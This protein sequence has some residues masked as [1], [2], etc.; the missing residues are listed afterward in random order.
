VR[1]HDLRRR[2]TQFSEA[3]GE[4]RRADERWSL[5]QREIGQDL[6]PVLSEKEAR[7]M[8]HTVFRINA[9]LFLYSRL[10]GTEH[11]TDVGVLLGAI[12]YLL[13]FVYDHHPNAEAGAERYEQLVY[14][15][16]E[17]D[18]GQ[19]VEAVLRKL[20]AQAWGVIP[21]PELFRSH[22]DAMLKTQRK[23]QLQEEGG[24]LSASALEQ[25]TLDK[26]HQSLCLFFSAVNASF[27]QNEA[28]ALRGFGLYMQYM[29][30]L[31]DFYEDRSESRMS[32]VR[33][34]LSG[35]WRASRLLV[36]ASPDLKGYYGLTSLRGYRIFMTWLW[37]FHGG[38]LLACVTRELTRLLPLRPQLWIDRFTERLAARNPFF[39]VAPIGLTY[40][41]FHTA[42]RGRRRIPPSL[43]VVAAFPTAAVC[44]WLETRARASTFAAL[45]DPILEANVSDPRR[46]AEVRRPLRQWALKG[47]YMVGAYTRLAQ[48]AP[49]D[50][51][52][53]LCGAA[54]R[55]Y[56]D[57]LE[58]GTEP[59]LACR[60]TVLF[61]GGDFEPSDDLQRLLAALHFEI[62]RRL[63]R[64]ASDPI[65]RALSEL[66][67][68]QMLSDR[69]R[70]TTIAASELAD[71]TFH[72]GALTVE[73]LY[74]LACQGMSLRERELVH[75]VGGTLQLLDDY[76]DKA[77]DTRAG[78]TT[79]ATRG[80][81]HWRELW[82]KLN[83][84]EDQ[85]ARYYG[86][87]RAA[88][89]V[90]ETR[91]QLLAAGIGSLTT[92]GRLPTHPRYHEGGARPM[93]LL[94]SRGSNVQVDSP[95]ITTGHRERP[96][97]GA[98][99]TQPPPDAQA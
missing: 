20:V 55:L 89:F 86:P 69:Q 56:D 35:A 19:P 39:Q 31:E 45:M 99:T 73:V 51:L 72:K 29:D 27:D 82:T 28:A 77:P 49:Q 25:L 60:L 61:D 91:L 34:P 66:H 87:R 62:R 95:S 81:I 14:L 18:N 79:K 23:S 84:L 76:Q 94:L 15:R 98:Q 3:M 46:R 36:A 44:T 50:P 2:W 22:L 11:D 71:I 92:K 40:Y 78:F 12:T 74:A 75:L 52:A 13:D 7:H 97:A 80:E 90:A 63:A 26:G 68:Y 58:S 9:L 88:R 57:L 6:A 42:E 1:R 38:I 85:L 24:E 53:L 65:F 93:R 83:G 17:A 47:G 59:S 8:T 33:N 70:D 48:L 54:G 43:G 96:A 30:D 21:D 64:P 16:D 37:L 4:C 67:T 41:D 10:R 5:M 32:P